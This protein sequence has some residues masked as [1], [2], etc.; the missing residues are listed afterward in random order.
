MAGRNAIAG[1]VA[2]LSSCST[3]LEEYELITYAAPKDEGST[4]WES[5]LRGGGDQYVL[6][7]NIF[8]NLYCKVS[9]EAKAPRDVRATRRDHARVSPCVHPSLRQFCPSIP[10]PV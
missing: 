1:A 9:T 7:G 10:P 5:N 6:I 3:Q 4:L 2:A 8:S